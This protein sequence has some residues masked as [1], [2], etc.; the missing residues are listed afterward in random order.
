MKKIFLFVAIAALVSG[1]AMAQEP[2]LELIAKMRE[3][4]ADSMSTMLGKVYGT[5]AAMTHTTAN[6]RHTY[7]KAFNE[8]L[9]LAQQDDEHYREGM[10]TGEQYYRNAEGMNKRLD[11]NMSRK[12]FV[13][14][15]LARFNDTTATKPINEEMRSINEE[16]KRLID[17]ITKLKKDSVAA[18]AQAALIDLK[19]DSLSQ[20]MG[21]FFGAQMQNM[22]NNKKMTDAQKQRF[23]EGFNSAVNIDETNK[24]LLDGKMLANDLINFERNIKKQMGLDINKGAFVSAVTT[25]LN[26]PAVPTDDDF[27]AIDTEAQ[28]YMR[29]TQAFSKENSPEALTQKGLGKRYIENQLEKDPKFIQAPSG[30]VYKILNPGNG[31]KFAATDKI[32]V[33]YKGTHVDG[34][35]FDESKQPVSFSPSQVVPGFKEALLMM[36]PGAKMIAILPYNLAYGERGAGQNIKPFETLVFEIETLGIDNTEP[37]AKPAATTKQAKTPE[38]K[39]QGT[40][41]NAK[42]SAKK[43]TGKKATGKKATKKRK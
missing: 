36:S 3:I 27:K 4:K 1:I 28:A 25:I 13:Q 32:K 35:T 14:A 18:L 37:A 6:A 8:A 42:M 11:I 40:K 16:A 22:A 31:K 19:A 33:M 17:D 15:F 10:N 38:A 23:M 2:D 12:A 24:P 21:H 26:N 9:S 41:T 20:N 39:E 34:T 29:A 5:Q 30:L 7:L 43:T